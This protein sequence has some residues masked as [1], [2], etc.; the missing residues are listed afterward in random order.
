MLTRKET[1]VVLSR[2]CIDLG[3]CLPFDRENEILNN[4]PDSV[5]K[6]AEAV[7]RAE[8]LNHEHIERG[9]Y[10]EVRDVIAEAFDK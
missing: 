6:F 4:P 8:G 1:E 10:R 5:D 3:F 2:L 9:L 7:I